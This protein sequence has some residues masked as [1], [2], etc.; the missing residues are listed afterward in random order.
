M[1]WFFI[2]LGAP[3]IWAAINHIDKYVISR[4]S[5]NRRPEALVIFASLAAGLAAV[6]IAFFTSVFHVS[7]SQA[8]LAMLAGALFIAG[9]I[10]YMY[11]L[12][13]DE[14]SI[15][16]PLWQMI[17]PFSYLLGVLFLHETLFAR[18][19]FAGAFIIIGAIILTLNFDK[20]SWKSKVFKLMTLASLLL[21]FNTLIFKIIGLESS[22]WIASFW[23]YLGAFCIGLILLCFTPIRKDF[24]GF[25]KEGGKVIVSLNLVAETMN[26]V[27]RLLFNFAALIAPI[28]LVY[29]VNGTQPFFILLYSL[30]LF[31]FFPKIEAGNFTRRHILLKLSAIAMMILGSSLLFLS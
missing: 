2:A 31:V 8:L 18:Q 30:I 10:P 25:L 1:S 6:I 9:Y 7:Y 23:E 15:A 14:V 19:I 26:V 4:Y 27:A 13:E 21:A 3:M 5:E 17:V 12:K 29:I 24:K 28:A 16:A 11:A 22:F 20:I